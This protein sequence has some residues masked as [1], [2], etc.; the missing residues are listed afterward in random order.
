MTAARP[1]KTRTI[2]L[3][4][5]MSAYLISTDFISQPDGTVPG[6]KAKLNYR[7][8]P[9]SVTDTM[10]GA[11][12]FWVFVLIAILDSA[13]CEVC[14]ELYG[15]SHKPKAR[16]FHCSFGCC[17]PEYDQYCCVSHAGVIVGIVFACIFGLAFLS[18]CV[19]CFLKHHGARG[20]M[21]R[22]TGVLNGAPTE[23]PTSQTEI[24]LVHSASGPPS[25]QTTVVN[26]YYSAYGTPTGLTPSVFQPKPPAYEEVSAPPPAY[27]SPP[28][29]PGYDE[30]SPGK[31]DGGG[32]NS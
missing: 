11:G 9:P 21:V 7:H 15:Y 31:W 25:Y 5:L 20:R 28:P 19:C 3:K 17:G 32:R 14:T 24:F 26:P 12:V 4:E 29:P 10:D 22:P 13:L 1:Q 23:Q 8:P 18:A 2:R 27:T 16:T 6:R 30:V